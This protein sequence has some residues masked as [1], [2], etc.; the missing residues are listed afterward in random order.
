MGTSTPIYIL[1]DNDADNREKFY[2][3]YSTSPTGTYAHAVHGHYKWTFDGADTVEVY[4]YNGTS[5]QI[6]VSFTGATSMD[7]DGTSWG[8]Y[9]FSCDA[10]GAGKV[11][12]W[13]LSASDTTSDSDPTFYIKRKSTGDIPEI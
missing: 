2:F 9:Y 13:I 5:E 6:T 11:Q 3:R 1:V 4:V 10:P 8:G 12:K 7:V